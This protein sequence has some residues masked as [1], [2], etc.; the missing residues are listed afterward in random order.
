MTTEISKTNKFQKGISGNPNGRPKGSQNRTTLLRQAIE[1]DMV[2]RLQ[3]DAIKILNK[4]IE[5]ALEGDQT[6]LKLLV[7]RLLPIRKGDDTD[8]GNVGG[9]QITI[10][11]LS[12]ES[13]RVI[14]SNIIEGEI[15]DHG[16]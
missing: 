11:N 15:I 3:K 2:N 8:K 4:T 14:S 13:E 5:M 16:K 6:C 9:I 1:G 10:Q 12:N 7:E